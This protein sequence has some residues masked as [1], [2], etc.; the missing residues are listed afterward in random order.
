M[1][2][3]KPGIGKVII[4]EGFYGKYPFAAFIKVRKCDTIAWLSSRR[5]GV[6]RRFKSMV[7]CIDAVDRSTKE[8]WKAMR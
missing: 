1:I 2:H 5:S 8:D 3:H 4:H 7:A 6:T